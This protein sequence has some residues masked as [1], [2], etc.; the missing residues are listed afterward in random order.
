[1][2][3][4]LGLLLA[5]TSTFSFAVTGECVIEGYAQKSFT[6]YQVYRFLNQIEQTSLSGCELKLQ[7]TVRALE[8]CLMVPAGR[9]S[10]VQMIFN[11]K[12]QIKSVEYVNANCGERY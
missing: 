3:L 8:Q 6:G 10:H 7:R 5:F 11:G 2:K 1:M 4:I 9:V 12:E